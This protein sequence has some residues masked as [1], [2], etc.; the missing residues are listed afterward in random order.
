M[1]HYIKAK[2]LVELTDEGTCPPYLIL[3]IQREDD[4]FGFVKEEKY[5]SWYDPEL[6]DSKF[7]NYSSS[8]WANEAKVLIQ[9]AMNGKLKPFYSVDTKEKAER[10][11]CS[12]S[13]RDLFAY[14]CRCGAAQTCSAIAE[15]L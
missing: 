11:V 12:C 1:A 8:D 3:L 2:Y 6:P 15:P 4:Y 9:K 5:D 10:I 14:G 7:L 13:S